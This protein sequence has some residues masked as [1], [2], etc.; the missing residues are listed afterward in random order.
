MEP[1][2]QQ[3]TLDAR[4]RSLLTLWFALTLSVGTFF[5]ITLLMPPYEDANENPVLS[6]TF[7]VV[8]MAAVIASYLI[9]RWFL[10][11]SVN[12]QNVELIQPALTGAGGF[13]EMPAILGFV[14]YLLTGNRYYYVLMIVALIGSL[15][16]FPRRKY[17]L[18]ASYKSSQPKDLWK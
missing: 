8:G 14:D 18:E 12:E 6:L 10:A 4:Y 15:L 5:L 9:R 17:L 1:A 13:S 11:R 3:V 2:N 7:L 16:N